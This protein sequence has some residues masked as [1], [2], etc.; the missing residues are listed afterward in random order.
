MLALLNIWNILAL[1]NKRVLLKTLGILVLP[2]K[3][4]PIH[5]L[6]LPN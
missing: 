6:A 2:N 5:T 4:V 3:L 1:L